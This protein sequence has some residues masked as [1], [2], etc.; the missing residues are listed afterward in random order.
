MTDAELA[1]DGVR[2]GTE[3]QLDIACIQLHSACS[4]RRRSPS[5][6]HRSW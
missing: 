3:G 2:G 5:L 6:P 4:A 1:T